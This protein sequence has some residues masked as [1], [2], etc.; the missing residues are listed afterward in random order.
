MGALKLF[1]TFLKMATG[2]YYVKHVEPATMLAAAP[3][4]IKG[5]DLLFDLSGEQAADE[6]AEERSE[7]QLALSE[8]EMKLRE[9]HRRFDRLV[10]LTQMGSN[11]LQNTTG[12]ARLNALRNSGNLGN[13]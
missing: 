8:E 10:G 6:R 4:V 7:K 1:Q 5:L 12:A 3:V 13:M 2:Q 11:V 9:Q